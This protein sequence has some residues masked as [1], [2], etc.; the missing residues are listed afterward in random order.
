MKRFSLVFALAL[1]LAPRLAAACGCFASTTVASP[2]VQ[3]G[4]QI[5]FYI[6]GPN[7]VAHVQI[8][9]SGAS[10]QFGWLLPLPAQPTLGV[11]D[12]AVFDALAQATQPIFSTTTI[13][14]CQGSRGGGGCSYGCGSY[15][16]PVANAAGGA[17]DN[18]GPSIVVAQGNVGP[19]DYAILHA[20]TRTEL[21]NWLNTNKYFV[22]TTSDVISQYIHT[23]AFFVAIKLAAGMNVGD[24]KPLTLTYPSQLPM[25]PLTLTS[26]T[27]A[28]NLP[29]TVYILGTARAIPRNYYHAVIDPAA[30]DWTTGVSDYADVVGRAVRETPTR[31]A[32]I[33]QFTGDSS[34]VSANATLEPIVSN[35]GNR[36]LTRLFGIFQPQDMTQDPVFSFNPDLADVPKQQ[37]SQLTV[38]CDGSATLTVQPDGL[39]IPYRNNQPIV[40]L[41][42]L[43]ASLRVE[44]LREAGQP[45][46]VIDHQSQI[47]AILDGAPVPDATITP[48]DGGDDG[49]I[50]L[51][52][53]AKLPWVIAMLPLLLLALR[54]RRS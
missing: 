6:D 38:A 28:A 45:E 36:K 12:T 30:L 5:L 11:G 37:S 2:V 35:F 51:R 41:A 32:F 27:S 7:V 17:E 52:G 40:P 3:A 26:A 20:D 33:T 19:Y 29:V 46:V 10:D 21:T 18:G 47:Q 1:A 42:S 43:P 9:Y 54:R 25:I 48:V 39:M 24:I 44:I 50:S 4:E 23:G 16:S 53:H 13:N 14:T 31:R 49:P 34:V 22:P 8:F 15:S